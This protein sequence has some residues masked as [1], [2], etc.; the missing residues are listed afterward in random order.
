MGSNSGL[1]MYIFVA[2]LALAAVVL[3]LYLRALDRVLYCASKFGRTDELR[4]IH[5]D[6]GKLALMSD[7]KFYLLLLT[8]RY[9]N[10]VLEEE[11]SRSLDHA[12]LYLIVQIPLAIV[13]FLIPF[14]GL[15]ASG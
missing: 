2:D 13:A 8:K 7:V 9:S 3:T 10:R 11:L 4:S 15:L 12:R 5:R 14:L 6:P 1:Y